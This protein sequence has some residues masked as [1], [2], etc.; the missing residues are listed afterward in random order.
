MTKRQKERL[1]QKV[2][3][4]VLPL[5]AELDTARALTVTVMLRYHEYKQLAELT[6]KPKDHDSTVKYAK[7]VAAT[8]LLRKYPGLPTGID[9]KANAIKSFYES[10]NQCF[11]T[12]VRL[13][14]FT[15]GCAVRHSVALPE[16]H[17]VVDAMRAFAREVLSEMPLDLEPRLGPGAT[18]S[19]RSTL[20][21]VPDKFSS[22]PTLTPGFACLVPV[23]EKTA[24]ARAHYRRQHARTSSAPE[25]VRGNKF[26]TVPKDSIKDRGAAKG[27]SLNVAY[28]LAVGTHIRER[29][30]RIGIDLK[31]G[32][33]KHQKLACEGSVHENLATIDL[34]SASDTVSYQLV[35]L[36]LPTLWFELLETLREPMTE[37]KGKWVLL[38]KYSAMGN[39]YTFELETLLFLAICHAAFRLHGEDGLQAIAYGECSV[40]GDDIIVPERVADTVVSL[41]RFF[42]FELNEKKSFLRGSFRESC[43]GDYFCGLEVTPFRLTDEITEPH[44]WIGFANGITQLGRRLNR[45]LGCDVD[46][47]RI[48]SRILSNLPVHI[49]KLTGPSWLGDVVIY[50]ET[51]TWRSR[52]QQHRLDPNLH[53]LKV[54]GPV[55]KTVEWKHFYG[56]VVLASALYGCDD[57][58]VSPRG[59]DGYKEKHIGLPM[60]A[61]RDSAQEESPLS[62][63]I[64]R[65]TRTNNAPYDVSTAC[66]APAK[67]IDLPVLTDEQRRWNSMVEKSALVF[68]RGRAYR[69]G[70]K[71]KDAV[72]DDLVED[73]SVLVQALQA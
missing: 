59:V 54:W 65:V 45:D 13:R 26:F 48:R 8:D 18:V 63:I 35:K 44:Q 55:R 23:W 34:S 60:F 56:D 69:A 11:R 16:I 9:R 1:D 51:D 3:D 62:R 5:L 29:L 71:S 41:L 37:V 27:P 72:V 21:T 20:A 61:W 50:D 52:L 57:S 31:T 33:E 67:A 64:N 24:W 38:N 12:N 49:R 7:S 28:Q 47:G 17:F 32:Q 2:L 22:V 40:Y 46:Y 10:E 43:G 25:M 36:I 70:R 30:Q 39:G 15:E 73:P 6:C 66:R 53:T 14:D 42:G 68:P 4:A 19:D 58:G